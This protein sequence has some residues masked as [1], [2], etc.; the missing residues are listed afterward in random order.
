MVAQFLVKL[1]RDSKEDKSDFGE[2]V[3]TTL[4]AAPDSRWLSMLEE[5]ERGAWIL[6]FG[7]LPI[8]VIAYHRRED[9]LLHVFRLYVEE[10]HCGQKLTKSG[11]QQFIQFARAEHGICG[12]QIDSGIHPATIA[13]LEDLQAEEERGGSGKLHCDIDPKTGFVEFAPIA[14]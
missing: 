10:G 2:F 8:G 12:V 9:S 11:L 5:S 6:F 4:L 13:V 14:V 1:I 7:E 3:R